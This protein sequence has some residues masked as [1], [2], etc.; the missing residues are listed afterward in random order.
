MKEVMLWKSFLLEE[1]LYSLTYIF[2][3]VLKSCITCWKKYWLPRPQIEWCRRIWRNSCWMQGAATFRF[4]QKNAK[5]YCRKKK[6][7]LKSNINK[8]FCFYLWDFYNLY[9]LV[10]LRSWAQLKGIWAL[11]EKI[12]PLRCLFFLSKISLIIV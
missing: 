9:R 6:K 7:R 4:S 3:I 8:N 2:A 1:I 10:D 11:K 12:E 5:I